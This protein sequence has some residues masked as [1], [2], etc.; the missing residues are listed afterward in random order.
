[1]ASVASTASC[2]MM[3]FQML[4]GGGRV[5]RNTETKFSPFHFSLQSCS[6]ADHIVTRLGPPSALIDS[7]SLKE[8]REKKKKQAVKFYIW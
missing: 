6:V 1:M 8:I 5:W 2:Q 3:D 4:G 7:I